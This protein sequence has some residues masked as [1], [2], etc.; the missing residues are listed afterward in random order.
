MSILDFIV[1]FLF[2]IVVA[3]FLSKAIGLG[4]YNGKRKIKQMEDYEDL[5]RKYSDFKE[6]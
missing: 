3:Y 2:L 4:F 5:I 6:E 1:V